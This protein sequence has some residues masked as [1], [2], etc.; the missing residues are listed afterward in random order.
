MR[1]RLMMKLMGIV[2]FLILTVMSARS[3][4]SSSSKSDLNPVNVQ[5][6]A[7]AGYCANQQVTNEATGSATTQQNPLS[8]LSPAMQIEAHNIGLNFNCPTTTVDNYGG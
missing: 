4:S 7:E 6:N 5:N 3:C 8:Q 2:V 1:A